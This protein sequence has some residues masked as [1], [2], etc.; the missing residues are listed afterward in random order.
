MN[1]F[2]LGE[3]I[4]SSMQEFFRRI[5]IRP[6]VYFGMLI[7]TLI[8][9][10]FEAYN[11]II[12]NYGSFSYIL[13][14]N[15]IQALSG[16]TVDINAFFGGRNAISTILIALLLMLLFSAVISVL[17][18]GYINIFIN[19]VDDKEKRKGEFVKGLEKNFFKTML[20]LFVGMVMSIP[21]F[22]VVLYSAVPTIF[23]IKQF[24]DGDT[25][26][27]F[28]MLL[29]AL[30]TLVVVLFAIIFFAMYFTYV[31]PAI[32]GLKRRNARS[33]IKMTN[34]YLWYLLPKTVLF[35]FVCAIIRVS[36]FAIHY[37]HQSV[38]LSIIVLLLTAILRS[39][40]Y[41][42]YTYFVFNT[43]IAMREDL[44]P[45]Y[46]EDVPAPQ[47][48]LARVPQ[49]RKKEEPLEPETVSDTS[50]SSEVSEVRDENEVI[51]D[52]YDDSFDD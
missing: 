17:L 18:S 12:K 49:Q 39:I 27:I 37:G 31:L 10:A 41:Y 2:V 25:G 44:Y 46:D 48:H 40:V 43:F 13:D 22:Y 11:P 21:L 36:L 47:K 26:V 52:E 32:A 33:G 35:L 8:L 29:M 7:L 15:Y 20:Y 14:R 16:W 38:V 50:E 24:L 1:N 34:T 6:F 4:M 9:G 28:T 51:D 3:K 42:L 5:K 45:D 19:A 30:L 23:M